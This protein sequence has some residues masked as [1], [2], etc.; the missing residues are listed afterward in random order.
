MFSKYILYV[1]VFIYTQYTHTL[2]KQKLLF[3]IWLIVW[4]HLYIYIPVLFL[5]AVDFELVFWGKC[6]VTLC[7]SCFIYIFPQLTLIERLR[8]LIHFTKLYFFFQYI[9]WCS[10]MCILWQAV[11]DI[12][13]KRIKNTFMLEFD[14][15][16]HI[17]NKNVIPELSYNLFKI[18]FAV[19]LNNFVKPSP[20]CFVHVVENCR[21]TPTRP[22][23]VTSVS[24]RRSGSLTA[25]HLT[26]TLTKQTLRFQLQVL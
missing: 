5:Q 9:F 1:C 14:A 17:L 6:Y 26:E 20:N 10:F 8:G 15:L 4:Q 25:D 11:C 19:N 7:T 21:K 22:S 16:D 18:D 24:S 13:L 12:I 23:S 3:W 2:C